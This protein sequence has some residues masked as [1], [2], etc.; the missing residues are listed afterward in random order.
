MKITLT[1]LREECTAYLIPEVEDPRA[2]IRR[3]FMPMFEWELAAWYTDETY[4]PESLTYRLFKEFFEIDIHSTVV[5]LGNGL[6][7]HE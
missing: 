1:E 2:W 7:R 4:W 5:D 6:V 3:H